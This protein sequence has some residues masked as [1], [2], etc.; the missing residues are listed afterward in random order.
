MKTVLKVLRARHGYYSVYLK[1]SH[2][3]GAIWKRICYIISNG[4]N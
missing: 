1:S 3:K 4:Y 2:L